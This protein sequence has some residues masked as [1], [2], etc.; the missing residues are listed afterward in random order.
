M[1]ITLVQCPSWT[2]QSPPYA[3]ALL[4]SVLQKNG[5]KVECHDFNIELFNYCKNHPITIDSITDIHKCW[6][7]DFKGYVWYEKEFT[8][9]FIEAYSSFI[10]ELI[11]SI[12]NSDAKVVGFSVQS[13]SKFFSLEIAKRLKRK[14]PDK[15]IVFG[16]PL[17]FR[18]CYGINILKDFDF[19]DAICLSEGEEAFVN[20]ISSIEAKSN[21]NDF[22]GLGYR[23]KDGAIIDGADR[24]LIPDLNKIPYA[25]YTNF[26]LQKYT[27]KLLPISTSRGCINRC[28][29]CNESVHWRK[30]RARTAKNIYDE[31]SY[32]LDKHPQ[33]ET[34]WFNDSL[35]NGDIAMLNELCDFFIGNKMKIKWGGQTMIR[36]EMD[37]DLLYKMK[38]AGCESISYGI[39]NGSNKILKLMRKGYTSELAHQVILDT[40]AVGINSVFNIIIGFPGESEAEF[41]ENKEFIKKSMKYIGNIALNMLLLLKDSYLYNNLAEFNI[42]PINYSDPEYQL[43]WKTADN[44]NTYDIRKRRLTELMQIIED[45]TFYAFS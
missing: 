7:M 9:K 8:L 2:T 15:V 44:S 35:I 14:C 16:G 21:V 32:Q 34:F 25:D 37:K 3:L 30:Y 20:L 1:K 36:R 6:D 33:I 12:V 43:K 41:E 4:K 31:I 24:L 17:C 11:A 40:Y 28:V 5:H 19:L 22:S 29:F 27:K 23:H 38:E 10:D 18:N 26:Y 13:T 39:E 45:K 42:L